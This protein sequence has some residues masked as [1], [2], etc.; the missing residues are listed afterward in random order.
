[1][2]HRKLLLNHLL[3]IRGVATINNFYSPHA[4]S[5]KGSLLN[6]RKLFK[7]YL[8]DG[9]IEQ[10]PPIGKPH[11]KAQEVFYCLTRKGASY[12]GRTNEYKYKKYKRSPHNIMHQSMIFDL[13]L[14]FLR[15]Y[16]YVRFNFRY[17]ASL[18]GLR[19]DI[20]IEFNKSHSAT[21]TYYFLTE[22]ERKKTVDRTYREKIVRYEKLFSTLVEEGYDVNAFTVLVVYCDIWHNI[23]LRP[24]QY[25]EI[26]TLTHIHHIDNLLINLATQYCHDL[27]PNRYRFLAFHNFYRITEPVWLKPGGEKTFLFSS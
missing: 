2:T 20:F 18:Y 21:E 22:I 15:S 3:D 16:P 26:K 10:I 25:S 5:Y 11:N 17:N 23:F 19:P 1:M 27:P 7:S 8:Q 14:S 9:L 6:T 24:T 12:I 13:A 4:K